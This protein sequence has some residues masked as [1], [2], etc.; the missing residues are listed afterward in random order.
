MSQPRPNT[1]RHH[2]GV[3]G[4][5]GSCHELVLSPDASLLIDCGLFQGDDAAPRGGADQLAIE[6]DVG[7]I[8]ALVVTHVHIDHVGRIP[9]LLAAGFE[10]PILCSEPSAKLLPLVLE[11]AFKLSV[12]RQTEAV[13][14]YLKVIEQ[15][16]VALPYGQWHRVAGQATIRLQRA[17]HILGSAYVECE[18][19]GQRT[20][21]SGDLG[22]THAPLLEPPLPPQHCDT[23]IIESTYGDRQHEHRD[24][25]RQRLEAVIRRALQDQGT[26]L[27]TA[28]PGTNCR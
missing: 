16:L 5:T 22:A 24:T 19:E 25:R 2:G 12:S 14:R 11:D 10:G 9:W 28:C 17:G 18:V 15:R 26:V 1:I 6:F 21:F 7:R 4:V 3:N 20:V 23:L 13:E 27:T 8:K